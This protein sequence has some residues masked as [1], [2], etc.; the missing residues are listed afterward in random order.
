MTEVV[1]PASL[2]E[3]SGGRSDVLVPAGAGWT[4][5]FFV[6]TRVQPWSSP[7]G[8]G[9]ALALFRGLRAA[10]DSGAV[11]DDSDCASWGTGELAFLAFFFFFD[12]GAAPDCPSGSGA[13][14][15]SKPPG[16]TDGNDTTWGST[17]V[18]SAALA[19]ALAFF[20]CFFLVAGA[21]EAAGCVP[22]DVTDAEGS[23]GWT[24]PYAM[25]PAMASAAAA[26][27]TLCAEPMVDEDEVDEEQGA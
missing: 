2:V 22:E 6:S 13:E 11:A 18:S 17:Y 7:A 26:E 23:P 27:T 5:F 4:A 9:V 16:T 15:A 3:M 20:F 21:D 10:E 8:F 19:T 14:G 1:I 25:A 12:L 24:K